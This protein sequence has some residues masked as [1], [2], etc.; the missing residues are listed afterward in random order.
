MQFLLIIL[1]CTLFTIYYMK[2]GQ[3]STILRPH[4]QKNIRISLQLDSGGVSSTRVSRQ[5]FDL[6]NTHPFL[7][8]VR[9]LFRYWCFV[10][11]KQPSLAIFVSYENGGLRI[12]KCVLIE[13]K[14]RLQKA[15]GAMRG[16]YHHGC[17][18]W[19]AARNLLTVDWWRNHFAPYS[20]FWFLVAPT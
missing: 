17:S 20:T 4:Q 19:M 15:T 18:M 14:R 6:I 7:N 2:H 13:R 10:C 16:L 5:V 8:T 9:K 3:R 1:V 11:F 12:F